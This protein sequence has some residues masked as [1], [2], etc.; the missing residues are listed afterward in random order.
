MLVGHRDIYHHNIYITFIDI[1]TKFYDYY[2]QFLMKK[3]DSDNE[4]RIVKLEQYQASILDK[5]Q[6]LTE[7]I[8]EMQSKLT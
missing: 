5:L 7:M 8:D 1:E 6:I 3:Y 4:D 2:P